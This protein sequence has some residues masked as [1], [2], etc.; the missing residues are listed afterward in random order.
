MLAGYPVEESCVPAEQC[1][2]SGRIVSYGALGRLRF[3]Q[4]FALSHHRAP[5]VLR[6]AA[7]SEVTAAQQDMTARQRQRRPTMS[8]EAR[9]ALRQADTARR[10]D[11][12]QRAAASVVQLSEHEV[13][14]EEEMGRVDP[15]LTEPP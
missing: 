5:S 9:Q 2:L 6:C 8:V 15:L 3:Q 4:Q 10:R 14:Q 12:R 7:Q 13:V 1:V 11:A